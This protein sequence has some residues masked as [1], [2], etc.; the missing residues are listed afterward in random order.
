MSKE[1]AMAMLTGSPAPAAPSPEIPVAPEAQ[2]APEPLKSTQF[3]AFAKKE[4]ELVR[5]RQALS[6]ER[7]TLEEASRQYQE[8]QLKKKEDPIAAMKM[9]GFSETDIFN[10]MAN[11][12]P[13][14]LT[15]EEKAVQAAQK[16]ADERI[17]AFEDA[18]MKKEQDFQATQDKQAIATFQSEI[19]KVMQ[20]NA[21]KFEYCAHYGEEAQ[22]LAYELTAA[23]FKESEGKEL[24]KPNEALEMAEN[25]YEEKDKAMS[26]IRKRQPP[27]AEVAPPAPAERSRT[28][29]P[30]Y[31]NQ[32]MDQPK[33][34]ISKTRTLTNAA[35][36][37]VASTRYAGNETRTQK[38][39]R[40]MDRL[41]NGT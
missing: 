1:A 25:Y 39:E 12:Q 20:T 34:T 3:N 15:S 38:R 24:L 18:Q 11:Q 5:Q 36:S 2:A 19:A 9:L 35:T 22:D 16:A 14:E 40:L 6:A 4:A 29:T 32:K 13:V 17:K 8:F 30:G 28:V 21:E 33:P 41:R 27:K 7:K 31:P 37:T 23:V 26:G 10:Y